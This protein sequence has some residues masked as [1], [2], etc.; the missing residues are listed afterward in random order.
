MDNNKIPHKIINQMYEEHF[1]YFILFGCNITNNVE[2]VKDAIQNTFEKLY[3][4]SILPVEE[5]KLKSYIFTSIRNNILNTL[6]NRNN[7]LRINKDI[8]NTSSHKHESIED[9]IIKSEFEKKINDALDGLPSR[10]Q[11]TFLLALNNYSDKDIANDLAVSV[12]AVKRQK[13]IAKAKLA[14]L[15]N[16]LYCLFLIFS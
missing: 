11:A 8:Y 5:S 14:L 15:R 2:D 13:K 12:N 16:K 1:E 10:C 9:L 6:R 7:R 4:K 3:S